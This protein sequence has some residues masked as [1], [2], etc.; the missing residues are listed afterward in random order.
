MS[1]ALASATMPIYGGSKA[2]KQTMKV[3]ESIQANSALGQKLMANA[4]R[5]ENGGEV[6]FT[7]VADYS[8]KFQ[9][10]HHISQWND[11]ADGEE[12]VRIATKG[13]PDAA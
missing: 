10:C 7:W 9:G 13:L 2:N 5:L 8:I 12:D 1:L 3:D 4:R 6:D 11:E